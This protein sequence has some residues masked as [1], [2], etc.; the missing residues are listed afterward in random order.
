M[1]TK[2]LAQAQRRRTQM[3]SRSSD[4]ED[5]HGNADDDDDD[6]DDDDSMAGFERDGDSDS[7]GT[8]RARAGTVET[9]R[10]TTVT[11]LVSSWLYKRSPVC[12]YAQLIARL[13]YFPLSLSSGKPTICGDC[14][15]NTLF[16]LVLSR[17]LAPPRS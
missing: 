2:Y 12:I 15:S 6:D 7:V 1:D 8:M 16:S 17:A 14:A 9:E 4:A 11:A 5:T 13:L 10:G 3:P